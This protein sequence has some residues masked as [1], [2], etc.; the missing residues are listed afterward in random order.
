MGLRPGISDEVRD[1]V[2]G[3]DE[4]ADPVVQLAVVIPADQQA[5]TLNDIAP[6]RCRS[7][8]LRCPSRLRRTS[9]SGG[10]IT[11]AG[12]WRHTLEE[13]VDV[14]RPRL[15]GAGEEGPELVVSKV[16]L[17]A[18]PLSGDLLLAARLP[19]CTRRCS[20]EPAP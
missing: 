4:I 1:R 19:V 2:S 14:G 18:I 8:L 15:G 12:R 17:E 10:A 20:T 9:S 16:T 5:M 11:K 7:S 13:E 6:E 3:R